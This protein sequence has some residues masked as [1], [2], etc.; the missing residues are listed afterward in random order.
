[1][2][3]FAKVGSPG[4]T[5]VDAFEELLNESTTPAYYRRAREQLQVFERSSALLNASADVLGL[6]QAKLDDLFRLA[7]ALKA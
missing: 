1:M 5:L 6:S 4:W 7:A 2:T 3:R